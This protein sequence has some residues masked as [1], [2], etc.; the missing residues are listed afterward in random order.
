MQIIT[1][2]RPVDIMGNRIVDITKNEPKPLTLD[3][4]TVRARRVYS[5]RGYISTDGNRG[6]VTAL[7]DVSCLGVTIMKK[8]QHIASVDEFGQAVRQILVGRKL[9]YIVNISDKEFEDRDARAIEVAE[10]KAT[11]K[12]ETAEQL[13]DDARVAKAEADAKR[14][15]AKLVLAEKRADV[16]EKAL[17]LANKKAEKALKAAPK[18][19]VKAEPENKSVMKADNK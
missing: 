17:K 12:A 8:G 2:L 15:E 1:A 5:N 11:R 7:Y 10:A 13:A 18:K 19:S 6:K 14:A 9:I 3:R 4:L 16:A